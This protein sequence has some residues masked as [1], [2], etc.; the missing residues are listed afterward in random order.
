MVIYQQ[1]L[2]EFLIQSEAIPS[3]GYR[4]YQ[5]L[6]LQRYLPQPLQFVPII[7]LRC[8]S[9]INSKMTGVQ[10]PKGDQLPTLI[11][12]T[13]LDGPLSLSFNHCVSFFST[14]NILVHSAWGHFAKTDNNI[15]CTVQKLF[16]HL[17]VLTRAVFNNKNMPTL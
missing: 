10:C 15:I 17:L 11:L 12:Y 8:T 7:I 4:I 6:E 2:K 1:R 13:A 14:T 3:I 5:Q 9:I 16:S